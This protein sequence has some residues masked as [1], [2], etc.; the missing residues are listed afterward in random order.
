[1]SDAKITALPAGTGIDPTDLFAVV[2]DVAGTPVTNKATVNLVAAAVGILLGVGGEDPAV[3]TDWKDSVAVATTANIALTGEQ[4][5]DGVLT[6]TSRVLVKNQTLPATNGIYVSAAGAW[7]RATDAAVSADVTSGMALLVEGGT[8]SAGLVYALVTTGTIT[9]GTTA[10]TFQAISVPTAQFINKTVAGTTYTNVLLDSNRRLI[11][12]N[13]GTKTM[14]VAPQTGGGG[15]PAAVGTEIEI[16]NSGAGLLTIAAGVGVTINSMG[17]VL[18]VPQGHCVKLK[19]RSNPNTWDV[20]GLP[21]SAAVSSLLVAATVAAMAAVLQ[22]T[23]LVADVVGFRN[24]PINSQ[25]AAY[26]TVAADS[27]KCILHPAAD[28]NARTVTI[29]S[30]ANVAYPVGTCITFANE[31]AEVLSIAITSDTLTL[32]GTTTSGTR[33]LAQNG[34]ATALKI[35]TTKW[36]ISGTGLT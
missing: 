34:T 1:M 33:S 35:T 25:S 29:D 13:A 7:S 14:T 31:T 32:A 10:L 21:M 16:L 5:I 26:T 19:K 23:G 12:T 15:V 9:L 8:I 36:I 17:S 2:Q 20:T 24:I 27:G 22:S 18:T 11:F 3:P 28:A 4:T 30:N 6:S